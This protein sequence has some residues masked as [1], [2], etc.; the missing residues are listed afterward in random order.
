LAE[1]SVANTAAVNAANA[2]AAKNATDLSASVYTAQTQTYRDLLE[3]SWKTG[4]AVKDR[5]VEI[6]KATLTS[7]A[8]VTASSNTA[9]AASTAAIGGAAVKVLSSDKAW[10]AAEKAWDSVTSW[11]KSDTSTVSE[12]NADD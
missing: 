4:E 5:A 3:Q 12:S 2:V 9:T 1:V 10:T 8:T 6:A 11:F 7:N